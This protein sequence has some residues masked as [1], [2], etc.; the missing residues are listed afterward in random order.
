MVPLPSLYFRPWRPWEGV[1]E[2]GYR[3]TYPSLL[4]APAPRAHC[5]PPRLLLAPGDRDGQAVSSPK[6]TTTPLTTFSLRL[7]F[8]SPSPSSLILFL[9]SLVFLSYL[10]PSPSPSPSSPTSLVS[11]AP[12]P[13]AHTLRVPWLQPICRAPFLSKL[14]RRL[15]LRPPRNPHNVLPQ[16]TTRLVPVP[17][18]SA[19]ERCVAHLRHFQR[20]APVASAP[21]SSLVAAPSKLSRDDVQPRE[22]CPPTVLESLHAE[23]VISF[24][25]ILVTRSRPRRPSHVLPH[26]GRD[27]SCLFR[28]LIFDHRFP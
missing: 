13:F 5:G 8:L 9:F 19:R 17:P 12:P 28:L 7:R 4:G 15:R 16:T 27:S 3:G 22:V 1:Q 21:A 14:R 20:L 23:P 10:P 2:G 6:L 24:F 25:H 18:V 11:S 26:L